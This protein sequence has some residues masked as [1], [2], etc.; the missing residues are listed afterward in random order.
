M[1]ITMEKL[2]QAEKDWS[3]GGVIVLKVGINN[4]GLIEKETSEYLRGQYPREERFRQR[5][6]PVQ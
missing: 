4:V 5:E 6:Q 3:G 2:K 1:I